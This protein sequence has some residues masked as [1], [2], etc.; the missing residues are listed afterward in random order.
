[1]QKKSNWANWIR[2]VRSF[3][4]RQG[5]FVDDAH[6]PDS[7]T[8]LNWSELTCRTFTDLRGCDCK[9]LPSLS[10]CLPLSLFSLCLCS[11]RPLFFSLTLSYPLCL[12]LSLPSIA[13]LSP[14]LSVSPSFQSLSPLS[15]FL[16]LRKG[17]LCICV[18]ALYTQINWTFLQLLY[19][20]KF[21][22]TTETVRSLSHKIRCRLHWVNQ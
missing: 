12:F 15:F 5:K 19:T 1:M 17:S 6:V 9:H 7:R 18:T 11:F 16:S 10:L 22:S 13:L 4:T 3:P 2:D 20:D 14:P 8:G 21:I